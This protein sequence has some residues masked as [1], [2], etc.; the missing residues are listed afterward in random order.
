MVVM[1][2]YYERNCLVLD[3][4]LLTTKINNIYL[5]NVHISVYLNISKVNLGDVIISSH[6]VHD[7]RAGVIRSSASFRPY[8]F[9]FYAFD[10]IL[11]RVVQIARQTRDIIVNLSSSR[12][13]NPTRVPIY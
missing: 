12:V 10:K 5:D 1:R 7:G 2:E 13:R 3:R 11:L 6:R 4:I 8:V 9:Y